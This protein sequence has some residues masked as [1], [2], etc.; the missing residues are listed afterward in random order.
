MQPLV[1]R[2]GFPRRVFRTAVLLAV[3]ATVVVGS[4]KGGK[5]AV[6]L[7]AGAGIAIGFLGSTMW[8]MRRAQVRKSLKPFGITALV[9]YPLVLAGMFLGFRFLDWSG[10]WLA[11]G[12]GVVLVSIGLRLIVERAA[13]RTGGTWEA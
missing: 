8:A 13:G 12:A 2:E 5:A 10:I 11:L 9:K 3:A 1:L 4:M 6:E 7:V